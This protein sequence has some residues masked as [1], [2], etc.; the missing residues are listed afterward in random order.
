[1]SLRDVEKPVYVLGTLDGKE[2]LLVGA[3]NLEEGMAKA[4]E[5]DK[6]AEALGLKTRYVL[7]PNPNPV[8]VLVEDAIKGSSGVREA[9]KGAQ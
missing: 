4:N 9:I 3:D 5:A 6:K 8:V 2:N 7:R 1:M